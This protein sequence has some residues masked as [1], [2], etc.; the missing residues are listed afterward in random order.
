MRIVF[1][2]FLIFVLNS[3]QGIYGV[4]LSEEGLR[5]AQGP[6]LRED[7]VLAKTRTS[8]LPAEEN[9]YLVVCGR[10]D[11]MKKCGDDVGRPGSCAAAAQGS[12][13]PRSLVGRGL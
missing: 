8:F 1:L 6:S 10:E 9:A 13:A 2:M 3:P 4:P 7:T 11:V 12:Y 5:H